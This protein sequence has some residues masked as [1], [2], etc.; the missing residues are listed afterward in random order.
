MSTLVYFADYLFI[1]LGDVVYNLFS[2]LKKNYRSKI[3]VKISLSD[4][5]FLNIDHNYEI[6][7]F[8]IL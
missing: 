8:L 5:F 2:L 7:Y 6:N 1:I 4:W 3:L